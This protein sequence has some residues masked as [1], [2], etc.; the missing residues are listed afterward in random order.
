MLAVNFNQLLPSAE[1][2]GTR[3]AR[4]PCTLPALALRPGRR[5]QDAKGR[6]A[7]TKITEIF[8]SKEKKKTKSSFTEERA[9]T[10]QGIWRETSEHAAAGPTTKPR[11]ASGTWVWHLAACRGRISFHRGRWGHRRGSPNRFKVASAFPRL[12]RAATGAISPLPRLAGIPL[13]TKGA[14]EKPQG[15]SCLLSPPRPYF[16]GLKAGPGHGHT[17]ES[18]FFSPFLPTPFFS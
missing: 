6:F 12:P 8:Y 4:F 17:S 2:R 3:C 18:P 13:R 9:T 14:L 7:Y 15:R 5:P 11:A 10:Q 16:L 1:R